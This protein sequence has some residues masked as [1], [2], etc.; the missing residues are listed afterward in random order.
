MTDVRHD[1]GRAG[2]RRDAWVEP[3][4]DLDALL[5]SWGSAQDGPFRPSGR[6]PD[7]QR[8]DG[9][10]AD[11]WHADGPHLEGWHVDGRH[12]DGPHA[13]G[14]HVEGRHVEGR[15]VD[16]RHAGAYPSPGLG[17]HVR[18]DSIPLRS[19]WSPAPAGPVPAHR[20]AP[21]AGPARPVE[22]EDP[23][24]WP[25]RQRALDAHFDGGVD[26]P[27]SAGRQARPGHLPPPAWAVGIGGRPDPAAPNGFPPAASPAAV[28]GALLTP[29]ESRRALTPPTFADAGA[30]SHWLDTSAPTGVAVLD[31]P[32]ADDHDLL[33]HGTHRGDVDDP[34]EWAPEE[35]RPPRRRHRATAYRSRRPRWLRVLGWVGAFA[36]V[37][38]L[39]GGGYGVYQYQKLSGNIRRV[40]ALAPGDAAIRD[41]ARQL[42]AENYLLI[43]SDTRAGANGRYETSAGQVSGERSDTTILAH[44]SP[45]RQ[46]AVLVSFPRD[47]WVRL[48]ACR[49]RTGKQVAEHDGQFNDAFAT[50]GPAC[51][52]LAV[53]RL[54]GIKINHYVQVDFTGFKT[55]VDAVGGV[56]ICTTTPL[57]DTESGLRL[58]TGTTLLRGEQALSYVRARY[59]IGDGS[60]LGRIQRQQRFLGAMVRTAT[61]TRL[62]VNPVALTRFLGAATGALT[63]DRAT[64][65]GDLKA[66]A[67]QLRDLDPK[68]VGFLTAPIANPAYNPPGFPEPAPGRGGSKVLLDATAGRRLWDSIIN[69]RPAAPKGAAG[70]STAPKA[71]VLTVAPEDVTV[72]VLN[73][74]GI[75]GLAR[76][77]SGELESAGFQTVQPTNGP[78]TAVSTVRYGPGQAAAARTLGAAVPGA[79]LQPAAGATLDLV[80]GDNYTGVVTVRSGDPATAKTAAARK[81]APT[82]AT[83]AVTAADAR[84]A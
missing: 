24:P 10:H 14:R 60:D 12:V 72:R 22:P 29:P 58:D 1:G 25:G 6:H 51:T 64:S 83:P 44:L 61:S 3:G 40:D 37:L 54:T 75:D 33:T 35:V 26:R 67:D 69:D 28:H 34:E 13:D 5:T 50:G 65:I 46:K 84:C 62:L 15:H 52:V 48:P 82:P 17:P 78:R 23:G 47:S 7:G 11:G 63:L 66:L 39:A 70:P 27:G 56:P 74:V 76:K 42:D 59:G 80:V 30:Y 57:R 45:N 81:K 49:D 21:A 19:G 43:G 32:A 4:H 31:R 9:R 38:I 77:V 55:M 36:G 2:R 16:G 79:V 41:G 8:T 53:Q 20:P 68:R 18:P 73:G 71:N